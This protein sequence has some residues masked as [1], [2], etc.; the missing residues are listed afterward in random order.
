[1]KLGV[2]SDVH[3][4][5]PALDAVWDEL[6]EKKVDSVVCL[7]DIVGVLGWPEETARFVRENVEYCIHGNHD[8]YI[9]S[10]HP[11]TP[12]APSQ[13]QEHDLVTSELSK[14]S[15][16]WLHDLPEKLTIDDT[17]IVAHA[18]PCPG[19]GYCCGCPANN[20][21][22]KKDW[23]EFASN[24]LSDGDMV[25]LGHTH[26]QGGLD[27]SKFEGLGGTIINPGAVGAPYYEDARYAIVDTDT[28]EYWLYRVDYDESLLEDR[29]DDL[30]LQSAAELNQN[31]IRR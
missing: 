20:Y 26:I 1:M 12:T 23:T 7:G 24:H 30:G 27:C 29:F 15:V 25:C 3:G 8:A 21:V 13:R 19:E 5:K 11:Y 16:E 28:H 14:E 9:R 31:Y 17:I 10:D 2:I 18:H 22:D 6:Q 4:N